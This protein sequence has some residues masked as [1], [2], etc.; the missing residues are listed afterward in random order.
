MLF[1]EKKTTKKV[2]LIKGIDTKPTNKQTCAS[3]MKSRSVINTIYIARRKTQ[4]KFI[5]KAEITLYWKVEIMKFG[6]TTFIKW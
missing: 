4:E 6:F 2:L 3:F 1:N 5:E